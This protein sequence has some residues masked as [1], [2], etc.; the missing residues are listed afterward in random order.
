M[1]RMWKRIAALALTAAMAVCAPACAAGS[2]QTASP[3][4]GAAGNSVNLKAKAGNIVDLEA[5]CNCVAALRTDGVVAVMED[6]YSEPV[7]IEYHWNDVVKIDVGGNAV[8]ALRADGTVVSSGDVSGISEWTDIVDIDACMTRVVGL[9]AD[10]T[11]VS[12]DPDDAVGGWTDIVDISTMYSVF[13]DKIF[14]VRADGTVVETGTGEECYT[15]QDWMGIV[16]ICAG[17]STVAGLRK[18]G[19]VII[20]ETPEGEAAMGAVYDTSG[21]SGI[22]ELDG[23]SEIVALKK[24]GTAVSVGLNEIG[25]GNVSR[26]YD[27]VDVAAGEFFSVGLKRDGTIVCTIE[28]EAWNLGLLC[29]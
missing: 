19:T 11:V 28:A 26:W 17:W 22:Q 4:L 6:L 27:L 18:D 29:G 10:G 15:A 8:V 3:V 1:T 12:T 23:L 20:S 5:G 16:D 9:K 2:A 7:C 24:D 21:W 13:G 14:G 25:A